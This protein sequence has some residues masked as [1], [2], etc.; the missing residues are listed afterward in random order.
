M[1]GAREYI[2]DW[3]KQGCLE[4]GRKAEALR[5]AGVIPGATEWIVFIQR[6][7]LWGGGAMIA[8]AAVFFFAYNWQHMGSYLKFGLA[9]AL[10]AVALLCYWRLPAESAAGK[11]ALFSASIFVGVLFALYGQ[12]YQTGAD[13]Y[14]LFAYW[15]I[16]ILPWACAGR[17][18]VLWVLVIILS[19][20]AAWFYFNTFSFFGIPFATRP[21]IWLLFGLNTA[22]LILWEAASVKIAWLRERWSI[23]LLGFASGGFMTAVVLLLIFDKRLSDIWSLFV[24]AAW[25]AA[26]Y[27]CYRVRTRDLFMLA[28]GVLSLIISIT[29]FLGRVFL[30]GNNSDPAGIFLILGIIVIGLSAAGSFWL[31]SV[32]REVNA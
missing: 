5:A 10:I 4:S 12:T 11:A 30:E 20:L 17:L 27:V 7:L 13:T 16:A 8:A 28:V 25:L 22:A 29:S 14:E 21:Q 3:I 19:N 18:P 1:N 6:L 23:R 2:D 24:Y 32:A 15:A 31:K 26:L 9:Q